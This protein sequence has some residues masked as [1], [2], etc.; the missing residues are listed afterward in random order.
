LLHNLACTLSDRF[1]HKGN[2]K[3]LEEAITFYREALHLQP[4]DHPDRS[5]TLSKLANALSH[6][7]DYK[8]NEKDLE[9]AI[10]LLREALH[11]LPLGHPKRSSSLNSIAATLSTRFLHQ[12][13]LGNCKDLEEAIIL[14]REALQLEP[15]GCPDRF[16]SLNNLA[17]TLAHR[18]KHKGNEN[19]LE[20]AITFFREA[21]DM[22]PV[23]HPRRSLSL[24]NLA[25][26]LS[27]RFKHQGNF[28]DVHEALANARS[29][30][31]MFPLN[32]PGQSLVH[33]RLSEI[34]L[35]FHQLGLHSTGEDVD[36][37]NVA[38]HHLKAAAEL[39]SSGILFRLRASLHWV[40]RAKQ[41]M[42]SSLLDAYA[43]SMQL[44]DAYM[45]AT[46]SVSSRHQTMKFFPPTLAVDAASCALQ[47]DD[48]CHA[49]ELLEQGRTL[50]WTQMSRF[51]IPLDNALECGDEAEAL[52]K[53]FRELSS[54]LDTPP[55]DL[56]EGT[57]RVEVEA[58]ATRYTHLV[59]QWSKVVEEI[60]RLDGFSRFLLPP[61]F[62]DLQDV[63]HGGPIVVLIASKLSC[64]AIIIPHRHFP[65]RV[66]L[67]TSFVKL[68]R[69]VMTLRRTVDP[70]D[71]KRAL[72]NAL[73]ELWDDVVS[74]VVDNLGQFAQLGSRIWWCPT[75]FFNFLP[76]HAAGEYKLGGKNLPNLYISS[77]TPS[78]SALTR[79][80]R[81]HDRPQLVPFAAIG[82]NHP[83]GFKF[84]LS[85][86]EPE[87]EL[88]QSLLSPASCVSFTKV[89][90][91]QS[92]KSVALRT[93][94]DHHWLH[95][96][97]HGIQKF[98]E[99]FNSAFLMRDE[100]LT[101]LDIT[102][103]DLSRHE[104]AFLSACETA[105]GTMQTPD[106]VIHLAAGLQFAGVKSVIGTLWNVEDS[107]VRHLVEAFYKN[108]CGDGKMNSKRAARSL[109]KA[110][111]S[112]ANNRDIPLD[113]RIVFIHIG[114]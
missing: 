30:L 104:F 7:F 43:T 11:L 56:P 67:N 25:N 57:P 83:P 79:A 5:S 27:V 2:E 61:L 31:S 59:D 76:L 50:I 48:V 103:T 106:E 8:G 75:S 60:R 4:L 9:E 70:E 93:L 16:P 92:T 99:P 89:N 58:E 72:G 21:L 52:V 108:F 96:A 97:C 54:I 77:Y 80:R 64:D 42:H 113:Q 29:A 17:T 46:A 36:S 82:Q 114:I 33:R 26:A 10:I 55:K 41:Y 66:R 45:S 102:Q 84:T 23:G 100:P 47:R 35:L 111:Q 98:E 68:R 51:R 86:V 112:L 13:K 40:S 38:I 15:L 14:L 94:Q 87:L 107:T 22:R 34:Y 44:L 81:G 88:V 101:L 85:S 3:D 32:H 1:K 37:L 105:V 109:H 71:R 20:E 62:S 69:M 74:Y 110:V 73:Q 78:L 65:V 6:R 18:F 19:D 95:L 28:E 63:A 24:N 12:G 90:S 39:T 91:V 53:K 49:V